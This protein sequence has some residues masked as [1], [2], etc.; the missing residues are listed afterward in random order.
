MTRI[1]F[2]QSINH[3]TSLVEDLVNYFDHMMLL[4]DLIGATNSK[5]NVI[6]DNPGNISFEING[7]KTDINNLQ[8]TINSMGGPVYEYGRPLGLQYSITSDRSMNLT[9]LKLK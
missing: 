3:K 1:E 6:G 8:Y 4:Y 7:N 5:I 2:M 9:I